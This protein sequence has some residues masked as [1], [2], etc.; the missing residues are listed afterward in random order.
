MYRWIT[1]QKAA[2]EKDI[3]DLEEE[4]EALISS[5]HDLSAQVLEV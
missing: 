3:A 2:L 5:L 1:E 4:K